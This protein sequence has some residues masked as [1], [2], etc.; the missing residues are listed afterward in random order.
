MNP[1]LRIAIPAVVVAVLMSFGATASAQVSLGE[2]APGTATALCGA[3]PYDSIP[4]GSSV[5]TYRVPTDGVI[6]SWRT[7][8]AAGAGQELTFKVFRPLGGK[9]YLIVGHDGP[10]LLVPGIVNNFVTNLPVKAGDLIGSND[11][12]ASAVPNACLFPGSPTDINI[13]PPL[14]NAADGATVEEDGNNAGY[15]ANVAASYQPVPTVGPISPSTGPTTG[16]TSVL[17]SGSNFAEVKQVVFGTTPAAITVNSESTITATAPP[18]VAAASVPVTVTTSG[19]SATAAQ[20]FT[21]TAVTAPAPIAKTCK[22]PKLEGKKLK[23]AKKAIRNRGCKVGHVGKEKG[24]TAKSG[25]VVKQN[26][27]PGTIRAAGSK[28]FVKLG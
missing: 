25:E 13:Y 5:A 15:K 6:T 14:G 2:V 11:M 4:G 16:G 12:N 18:T 27:K 28:V 20:M 22:V 24:V 10:R 9:K 7:N 17:I 19:G 26:P 23:G 3:G 1:K 8:A 21:Y